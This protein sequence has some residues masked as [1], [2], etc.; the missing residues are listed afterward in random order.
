MS[1]TVKKNPVP[2]NPALPPFPTTTPTQGATT[3]PLHRARLLAPSDVRA[4]FQQGLLLDEPQSSTEFLLGLSCQVHPPRKSSLASC[5]RRSQPP[6]KLSTNPALM[7]SYSSH[8]TRTITRSI[9]EGLGRQGGQGQDAL[10][11]QPG[12]AHP[13]SAREPEKRHPLGGVEAQGKLR[14]AHPA[15]R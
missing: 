7:A 1:E 4:H 6:T 3:H 2:P 8:P 14:K 15:S 13:C 10:L 12:R 11:H 5:H 9:Q